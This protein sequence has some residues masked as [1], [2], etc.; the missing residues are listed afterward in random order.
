LIGSLLAAAPDCVTASP[1]NDGSSVLHSAAAGGVAACCELLL[2]AGANISAR[3]RIL[4]TP[5][6]IACVAGHTEA[7]RTL[8]THRADTSAVDDHNRTPFLTALSAQQVETAVVVA[9][10][11]PSALCNATLLDRRNALHIAAAAANVDWTRALLFAGIQLTACDNELHT[12]MYVAASVGATAVVKVMLDIAGQAAST[13]ANTAGREGLIA[14]QIAVHSGH[15]ETAALLADRVGYTHAASADTANTLLH[16]AC[17]QSDRAPLVRSL[18][19]Q[20][21]AVNAA[22]EQGE[23][24]LHLACAAQGNEEVVRLLLKAVCH[25]S[26][27]YEF[28]NNNNNN[29]FV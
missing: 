11:T 16:W 4:R 12:P 17:M 26:I 9:S 18:L 5:L 15:F 7:V 19:R 25:I 14:I 29:N 6:H 21:A 2:S 8:L 1:S 28:V 23:I 27:L 10:A 24:P 22:N 3:D 20:G 13:A